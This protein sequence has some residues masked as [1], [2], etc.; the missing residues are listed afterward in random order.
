MSRWW[1]VTK[2][3]SSGKEEEEEEVEEEERRA[4]EIES[5]SLYCLFLQ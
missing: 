4:K 2:P 1:S 5:L 3:D